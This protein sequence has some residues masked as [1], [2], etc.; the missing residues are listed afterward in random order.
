MS[1]APYPPAW[2]EALFT[3]MLPDDRAESESGDLLEVYRDEQVGSRGQRAADWWYV[4]QVI[5]LFVRTYGF[6]VAAVIA[7]F[8][9]SDLGNYFRQRGHLPYMPF[10]FMAVI[11]VASLHG[12]WRTKRMTGGMFVGVS[13]AALLWLF[14]TAWWLMTWYRALEAQEAD[15]YWIQAWHYSGR[16]G[17]SFA[18]WLF[19]DNIGATLVSFFLLLAG[20]SGFGIVGGLAGAAAARRR[21]LTP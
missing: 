18:H 2:A 9:A 19:V 10:V 16:P 14:M 13:T 21:R 17:E 15:P 3:A 5:V 6:W 20:G 8:V 4:R 12:G 11:F 1:E 7:L